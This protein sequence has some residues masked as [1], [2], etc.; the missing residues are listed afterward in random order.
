[1]TKDAASVAYDVANR[2]S[3][4]TRKLYQCCEGVVAPNWDPFHDSS[5]EIIII[6]YCWLFENSKI[7]FDTP[8]SVV[9]NLINSHTIHF[10]TL[11]LSK[12]S[13]LFVRRY[14]HFANCEL[15]MLADHKT[16]VLGDLRVVFDLTCAGELLGEDVDY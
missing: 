2:A 13:E 6:M 1:M 15:K 4:F 14:Q 9:C 16:A 11:D 3:D 8:F 7:I 5:K 10:F 12:C